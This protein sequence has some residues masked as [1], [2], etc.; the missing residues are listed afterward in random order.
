[1]KRLALIIL[2]AALILPA[3][4]CAA[5]DKP[6]A[7][8]DTVP[9]LE[10]LKEEAVGTE[11]WQ[12]CYGDKD[13]VIFT[14]NFGTGFLFRYNIR[15]NTIDRALDLRPL[16]E[17]YTDTFTSMGVTSDG[18]FALVRP[19]LVPHAA[20]NAALP[21][22]YYY[23]ADMENQTIKKLPPTYGDGLPADYV[24][25][26]KKETPQNELG[27][28]IR[29]YPRPDIPGFSEN[30]NLYDEVYFLIQLIQQKDG[31][32]YESYYDFGIFLIDA[33]SGETIQ[34]YKNNAD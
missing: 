4:G 2:C 19:R 34:E 9:A 13:Y 29:G 20:E 25:T 17:D 22:D 3:A 21:P 15:E 11:P 24:Y 1:M 23:E 10:A 26:E 28:K 30:I 27:D 31:A 12:I 7:F 18:R 14:Y 33:A 8:A 16:H 6:P 5:P 32:Q